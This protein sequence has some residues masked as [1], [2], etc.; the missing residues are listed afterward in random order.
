[1]AE[2]SRRST[3]LQMDFAPTNAN[4]ASVPKEYLEALAR[5][6]PFKY[7]LARERVSIAAVSQVFLSYM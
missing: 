6:A 4:H 1:M 2:L 7:L 3:S 5:H